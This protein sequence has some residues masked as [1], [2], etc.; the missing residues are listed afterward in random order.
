[1]EAPTLSKLQGLKV[2][3]LHVAR[4]HGASNVLVFGSVARNEATPES[5]LDFLVELEPTRSLLDH[6]ALIDELQ[7]VLGYNVD[8]ATV[9]GLKASVKQHILNEA[10]FL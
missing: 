6:A 9:N 2:E 7:E 3:I 1:M 5:D 8:V 4:K 10:V